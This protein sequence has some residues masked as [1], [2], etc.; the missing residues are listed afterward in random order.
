MVCHA[1]GNDRAHSNLV[2]ADGATTDKDQQKV[3][4]FSVVRP[5][6]GG[7]FPMGFDNVLRQKETKV[8]AVQSE[9]ALLNFLTGRL[10]IFF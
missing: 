7:I 10:E 2:S 1:T 6:N 4:S 9:R 3:S 8:Q 5:L